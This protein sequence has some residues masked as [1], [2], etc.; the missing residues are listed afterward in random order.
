MDTNDPVVKK[1]ELSIDALSYA[2]AHKLDINNL[3]DVK[4]ILEGIGARNEDP[5]EFMGLLQKANT[6]MD[7]KA[8]ERTNKLN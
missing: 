5:T 8:A 1:I 4:K 3:E 7:M 6:F 2:V